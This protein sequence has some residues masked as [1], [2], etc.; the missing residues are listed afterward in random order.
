MTTSN[1]PSS[2]NPPA[3]PVSLDLAQSHAVDQDTDLTGMT[4]RD[5]FAGQALAALIAI[6][7]Q[8]IQDITEDADE[9]NRSLAEWSY[10]AA[11]A[12]IAAREGGA[13]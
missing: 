13:S 3:F 9:T 11:N 6:K 1:L 10:D 5:Y 4:L 7:W 8:H 12:M 2:S